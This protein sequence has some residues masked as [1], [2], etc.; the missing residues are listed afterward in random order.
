MKQLIMDF[1]PKTERDC[2]K[3]AQKGD[4][5]AFDTL[6]YMHRD[7]LAMHCRSVTN[8]LAESEEVFQQTMIKAWNALPQFKGESKF[9]TWLHKIVWTTNVNNSKRVYRREEIGCDFIE[10]KFTYNDSTTTFAV[11]STTDDEIENKRL[12]K[13]IRSAIEQLSYE[14]KI[15]FNLHEVEGLSHKEIADKI[16]VP[17][18]TIRTRLHYAKKQLREILKDYIR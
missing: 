15:V 18:A 9:Y 5:K 17:E 12:G 13:E 6:W 8:S 4:T 2:I 7:R 1:R 10:D 14:H 3:A 11:K 16:G